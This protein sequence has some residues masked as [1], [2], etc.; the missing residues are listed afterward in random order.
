[1]ADRP[2]RDERIAV[3]LVMLPENIETLL[4]NHIEVTSVS[5]IRYTGEA[6]ADQGVVLVFNFTGDQ[7]KQAVAKGM[8]FTNRNIGSTDDE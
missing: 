8:R 6:F 3:P 4:E 1:M 7:R 2:E 5:L